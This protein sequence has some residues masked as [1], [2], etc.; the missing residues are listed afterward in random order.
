MVVALNR[1]DN[2]VCYYFNTHYVSFFSVLFFLY[3]KHGLIIAHIQTA[4]FWPPQAAHKDVTR[5]H[6]RRHDDDDTHWA[7]LME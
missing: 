1:Q 3:I 7:L 4:I 6:L 5:N 2:D